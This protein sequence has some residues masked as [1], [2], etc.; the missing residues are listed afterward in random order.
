MELQQFGRRMI[1]L[2]P[3]LVRGFARYEHNY[4]SRGEITLP[5]LWALEQLNRSSCCMHELARL[6][7]ISRPAATG[8]IDRLLAQ[9]MV[10]REDDPEDR[11][12]VRVSITAKGRRVVKTIWE[13]KRRMIVDVFGRISPDDRAQYLATVEQVVRILGEKE[14][15]PPRHGAGK[16][17]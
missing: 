2:L 3:Q 9:E 15:L 14:L 10:R 5:Q 8:L 12:M 17:A 11:R 4:L 1:E 6:L 16:P 13:Q 7:G